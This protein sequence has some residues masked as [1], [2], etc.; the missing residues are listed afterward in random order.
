MMGF[1]QPQTAE[2]LVKLL[3]WIGGVSATALGAWVTS[4]VRV[5][6]DERKAHL[7]DLKKRVLIPLRN[8]LEQHFRGLVFH[9]R[10]VVSVQMAATTHF[11]EKAKATEEPTE[12][13][14]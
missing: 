13:G 5:Y 7:D 2:R 6:H 10:P 11:D 1:V 8:G 3:V 12:Q 4:K 14:D 9:L